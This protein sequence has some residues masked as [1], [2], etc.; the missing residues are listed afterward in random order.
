M[1]HINY[2]GHLFIGAGED[3]EQFRTYMGTVAM[4]GM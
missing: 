2:Q 1:L 4:L 3:F